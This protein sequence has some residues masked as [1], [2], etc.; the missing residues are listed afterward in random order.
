[1]CVVSSIGSDWMLLRMRLNER[2][3]YPPNFLDLFTEIRAEEEHD[4]TR[5]RVNTRVR[6]VAARDE[7]AENNADIVEELRA[8][9]KALKTYVSEMNKRPSFV[10]EQ[11][12]VRALAPQSFQSGKPGA[13]AVGLRKDRLEKKW[14]AKGCNVA[15]QQ[16]V[17]AAVVINTADRG[18]SAHR[19]RFRSD[20]DRFCYRCGEVGHI[21][22]KCSSPENEKRVIRRLIALLNKAKRNYSPDRDFNTTH[23]SAK[24]QAVHA[25]TTTTFPKGLIGPPTTAQVKVN[26]HPCTEILDSGS[27]VTIILEKWYE[28]HLCNVTIHPVSGLAIWGLSDTSYPYL[29]YVLVDMQFPKEL[30]GKSETLSVLA[31]ICPGPNTPDQVP[32]ILGTNASV[33]NRLAALCGPQQGEILARTFNISEFGLKKEMISQSASEGD[34]D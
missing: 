12:D 20:A 13:E 22:T 5:Q 23:C 14:K 9:F 7:S 33:F 10:E 34:P 11:A 26:G 19:Q 2:K 18:S 29:G 8:D 21:A 3:I 16:V 6:S 28:E 4:R 31:L 30:V 25:K 32:V 24:K 17:D 1:M 15:E 27:Q